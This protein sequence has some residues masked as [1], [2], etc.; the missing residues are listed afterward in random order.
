MAL[1]PILGNMTSILWG[2]GESMSPVPSNNSYFKEAQVTA[3]PA[4]QFKILYEPLGW[5]CM[6]ES[7]E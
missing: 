5:F 2:R 6:A 7:V 4:H 1:E 3:F